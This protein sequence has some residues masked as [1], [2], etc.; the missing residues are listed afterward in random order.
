MKTI[1]MYVEYRIRDRV[2]Y[3]L[4]SEAHRMQGAATWN[5]VYARVARC[6]LR[7]LYDAQSAG[8]LPKRQA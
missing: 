7:R 5:R 6:L 1:G 2:I 4:S 8:H 3:P